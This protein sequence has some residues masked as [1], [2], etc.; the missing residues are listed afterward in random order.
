MNHE[1]RIEFG[2]RCAEKFRAKYKDELIYF[3]LI[4]STYRNE[5]KEDSDIDAFVV[6]K[7]K[8][9]W[10]ESKWSHF[11]FKGIEV[12]IGYYTI[13][14]LDEMVE[15]PDYKWPHRVF[16]VI[17]S[18]PI[19][20]KYDLISRYKKKI[21][22]INQKVFNK[23]AGNQL[24]SAAS[25]LSG[26]RRNAESGNLA[27]TRSG[28]TLATTTLDEAVA[29]LNRG[30]LPGGGY[31]SQNLKLITKYKKL[32][33]DYAKL[34]TIIW[35]SSDPKEVKDAAV[36]IIAKTINFARRKGVGIPNYTS[37]SRIPV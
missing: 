1:E 5:D 15:K 35:E 31:G 7:D 22:K 17:N 6:T 9:H 23:A 29:F 3:G 14:E 10:P 37:L 8:K 20:E 33:E 30:F 25:C 21:G 34:N 24:A 19:Y 26:I 4:G 28:A 2:K 16:R 12:S 13:D 18:L 32:P 27:G 36:E 11:M